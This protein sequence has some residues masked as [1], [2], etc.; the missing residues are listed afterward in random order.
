MGE[1]PAI[2]SN[3]QI[4]PEVD[5]TSLGQRLEQQLS[6]SSLPIAYKLALVMTLLTIT[7]MA[8][9]GLFLYTS[10]NR[11]LGQQIDAYGRAMTSQ[12]ADTA[13]EPLLADDRLALEV[14]TSTLLNNR[15]LEGA[16]IY[17]DQGDLLLGS[18]HYPELP[19][20]FE[21]DENPFSW[22]LDEASAPPLLSFSTPLIYRD[23]TVGHAL[24]TFNHSLLEKARDIAWKTVA[25]I[26]LM[27]VI[28]GVITA[29]YMGK[30]L[31]RPIHMLIDGSQEISAGNYH[32][33]FTER[34]NDELGELIDSLNTMTAGLLRKDHVEQT[35]SRYVSP[36][37]ASKLL[38]DMEQVRLGG[39]H[40][41]AT[42]L[43]ADIVGFTHL[44]EAMAPEQ[45]N[46]LLNDYF[47]LINHSARQFQ[48]HVD[49]YMGDC[50]MLL[51]GVPQPDEEHVE[52][53]I[54][55][56]IHIQH[57]VALCN[58]DRESQ[59]Q[60][61][62]EFRIGINSGN[63]LA[64]NMGSEER[65]D[66]TVVGDAVNLASRLSS[67]GRPGDIIISEALH[68]QYRINERFTTYR[69]DA[70]RLRGKT[71]PVATYQVIAYTDRRDIPLLSIVNT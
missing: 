68:D 24:L 2:M 28:I 50:A 32:F 53:A 59:G 23:L 21:G 10:Q 20:L 71:E 3:Q 54:E 55:C 67:V 15:D 58:L 33:R 52:H 16:A 40:V 45:V 25:A 51:F 31:T 64:G 13:L 19:P 6:S 4:T 7:G 11:L 9:L 61:T 69:R 62:A 1:Q 39:T 5:R 56:A 36:T 37:L 41:E 57:Q 22:R 46:A 44:S 63:M 8:I 27:M 38:K 26:T 66:Y 65:M 29:F 34:R 43:F 49:K 70:I 35:L 17:S 14:L 30:R 48:G 12:L 47:T 60:V 42:V 18:G